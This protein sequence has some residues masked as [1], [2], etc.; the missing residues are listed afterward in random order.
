[1]MDAPIRFTSI[2]PKIRLT[3]N[4][5]QV[6]TFGQIFSEYQPM[7]PAATG[8]LNMYPADGPT[9]TANPP[10]PPVS[11]GRPIAMRMMK[12][13][14][15]RAPIRLPRKHPANMTPSVWAVIGT[16]MKPRGMGGIIPNTAISAANNAA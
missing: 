16:G 15:L 1:M 14:R 7:R 4:S 5:F 11:T 3:T 13:T 6:W 2:T 8:Q 10:R 12:I 9:S